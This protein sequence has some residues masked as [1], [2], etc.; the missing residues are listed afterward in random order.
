MVFPLL[1]ALG[2]AALPIGAVVIA[3]A[4]QK[5]DDPDYTE[6]GELIVPVYRYPQPKADPVKALAIAAAGYYLAKKAKLI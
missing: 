1:I 6:A 5:N 2:V 4:R 3:K